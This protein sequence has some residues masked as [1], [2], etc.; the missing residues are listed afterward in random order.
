[1]HS[2]QTLAGIEAR[3]A[4]AR[5]IVAA[6]KPAADA[7]QA[8][9]DAITPGVIGQTGDGLFFARIFGEES[10][11]FQTSAMAK[12]WIGSMKALRGRHARA[13]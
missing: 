1:M 3:N 10:P 7:A 13:A 12:S 8:E 9:F 6:R 4:E 11:R 5:R 2:I